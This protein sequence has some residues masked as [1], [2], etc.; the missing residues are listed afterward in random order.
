MGQ[1]AA[2]SK[3]QAKNSKVK[4][5]VYTERLR[6]CVLVAQIAQFPEIPRSAKME[7]DGAGR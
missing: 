6:E 5:K 3:T 4:T 7:R 1:R 2:S